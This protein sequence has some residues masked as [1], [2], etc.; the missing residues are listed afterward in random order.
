[1]RAVVL[2]DLLCQLC[3]VPGWPISRLA[4]D[5]AFFAEARKISPLLGTL[6]FACIR[7]GGGLH[8]AINPPTPSEILFIRPV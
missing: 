8:R 7:V 5:R 2:H 3:D 1:M 6:Y 4:A